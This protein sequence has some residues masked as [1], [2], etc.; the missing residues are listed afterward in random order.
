MNAPQIFKTTQATLYELKNRI[1]LPNKDKKTKYVEDMILFENDTIKVLF[2]GRIMNQLHRDI[3]D[4]IAVKSKKEKI[5]GD[6]VIRYFSLKSIRKVF[7]HRSSAWIK[8]FIKKELT[9]FTIEIV[10]KKQKRETGM[11]FNIIKYF[12]YSEKE[13][14]FGVIYAPEYVALFGREIAVDY[15]KALPYILNFKHGVTKAVVRYL[16]T[17][18][19]GYQEKLDSILTKVGVKG[20]ERNL[21]KYKAQ[22]IED[23]KNEETQKNLNIYL[24]KNS[25]NPRINDYTVVYKR[26]PQI[27]IYNTKSIAK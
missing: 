25:N 3:L 7:K 18:S 24:Q 14:S 20:G 4:I 26:N 17:F 1:F 6:T 12:D 2:T 13:D 21:R 19:N 8:N 5:V 9:G 16:L 11:V 27:K 23:L 15:S 10:N 22:V